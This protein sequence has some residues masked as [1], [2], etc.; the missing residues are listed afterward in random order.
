[1]LCVFSSIR[2]GGLTLNPRRLLVYIHRYVYIYICVY[3]YIYIYIYYIF[4]VIIAQTVAAPTCFS[5]TRSANG[6][7]S[8]HRY[9]DIDIDID[10]YYI[11]RFIIAQTVAAPTCS[12]ST[13]SASGASIYIYILYIFFVFSLIR[14]ARRLSVLF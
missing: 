3:I 11:F 1:M 9:I 10:I 13:P 7:S 5:S 6:A 2:P 12:F 14:P 8:I 4:R